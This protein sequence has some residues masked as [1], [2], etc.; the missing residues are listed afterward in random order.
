MGILSFLFGDK[1]KRDQVAEMNERVRNTPPPPMPP[2]RPYDRM[3]KPGSTRSAATL[4]PGE[5]NPLDPKYGSN[6][7]EAAT[8]APDPFYT[9]QALGMAYPTS[10]V[11]EP[12][13][14]TSWH[15]CAP[16]SSY[17]SGSSYSSSDSSSSCSSSSS[18][19]G[20]SSSCGSCD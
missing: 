19:S 2:C 15:D 5:R 11:S 18:D 6:R 7:S 8:P 14:R 12:S 3:A 17:D 16:P 20:S 1:P 4:P 9:Q 10:A 13:H